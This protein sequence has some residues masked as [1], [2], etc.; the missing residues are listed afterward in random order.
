MTANF[1]AKLADGTAS[2]WN[3]LMA[4]CEHLITGTALA[5][6]YECIKHDVSHRFANQDINEA[7]ANLHLGGFS[8]R[9]NKL[10]DCIEIKWGPIWNNEQNQTE[11]FTNLPESEL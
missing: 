3:K 6:K 9:H 2:K 4:E 1:A 10:Y 8:V 11:D 5:G 7:V